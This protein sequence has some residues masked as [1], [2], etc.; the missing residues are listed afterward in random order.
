VILLP[1]SGR[2]QITP[3]KKEGALEKPPWGFFRVLFKIKL[4][5]L[6]LQLLLVAYVSSYRLFIQ[7]DGAH[8]IPPGPKMQR[9]L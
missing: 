1:N 9:T 6:F 8:A 2:P 4:K 5:L 7:T 3:Q